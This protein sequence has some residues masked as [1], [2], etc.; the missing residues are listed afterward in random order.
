M[1]AGR[2]DGRLCQDD[3]VSD[4]RPDSAPRVRRRYGGQEA[5]DRVAE[6]RSKLLAAGLELMGTRGVAGTTVRGVTELSGVAPRYFYESFA[7]IEALH[8]AVYGEVIE[9]GAQRS[10][11]ALAN[12]PADDHARIRAVLEEMVDLILADPRK[13]RILVLE[14][15]A[16]PA[17]GRR[18]L[19]ES[20][21]FAG[22]LASSA[23]SGG[24]PG[25]E[26]D[27]L[28]TD[29]RLIAQFLVGGMIS[30]VG[31][32]LLG[33]VQVERQHLV[34]VLVA[35]FAAVRTTTSVD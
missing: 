20:R 14:A 1:R 10:V 3:S 17:L 7:D 35:M 26:P 23:A 25:L 16:S 29:I 6:R 13:G 24:D 31:A 28:P 18:S 8:L 22:M 4:P 15:T 32:V 34:D 12:A 27:S 5:A 30:T 33:D 9:E 2:S 19:A 11:T 21:R